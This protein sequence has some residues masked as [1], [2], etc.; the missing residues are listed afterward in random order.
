MWR[1]FIYSILLTSQYSV[2]KNVWF[3]PPI[4]L[5]KWS[6]YLTIL[7]WLISENSSSSFNVAESNWSIIFIAF[8]LTFLFLFV[9]CFRIFE[10]RNFLKSLFL[11]TW[12]RWFLSH[13]PNKPIQKRLYRVFFLPGICRLRI[14]RYMNLGILWLY[15]VIL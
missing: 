9:L 7:L 8:S 11:L 3:S 5:W 1:D 12:C 6:K 10:M 13:R 4:F 15:W 2:I 14:N